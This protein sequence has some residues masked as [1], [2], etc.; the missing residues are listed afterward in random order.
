MDDLSG[1]VEGLWLE[2]NVLRT[3]V[4][5]LVA[6]E[7]RRSENPEVAMRRIADDLVSCFDETHESDNKQAS[8]EAA[9]MA[10][11]DLMEMARSAALRRDSQ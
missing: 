9:R 7:A 4:A 1:D 6:R 8:L 2:V 11:D 5:N 10:I 3:V